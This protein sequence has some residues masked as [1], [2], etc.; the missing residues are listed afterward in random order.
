[1]RGDSFRRQSEMAIEYASRNGLKLD[2][3]L[4]FQD[5]GVS[6]FHGKNAETGHLREFLMAVESGAVAKGSYL[7]VESLD[8]ISRQT[9]RKA[10]NLLGEIADAGITI[11]TLADGRAYTTENLD[12]DPMA[13]MMALLIF[14]RANEE[15]ATKSRR[16]RAAWEAKRA[17]AASKPLTA[18]CPAWLRL[19]SDRSGFEI[20]EERAEVVRG[21][22]DMALAGKGQHAI[23]DALNKRGVAT[24][25]DN[26]RAPAAHW[27]RSYV[28]KVLSSSSVVGSYTPRV[29]ERHDGKRV[30]KALD[31]V[32]NYYPAIVSAEVFQR[33]AI[34][35]QSANDPRRGRNAKTPTRHLLAGLAK[36]PLCGGTMTRVSKGSSKRAGRPNLVCQRA[37]AGAGCQYHSVPVEWVD[38]ALKVF[39]DVIVGSSPASGNSEALNAEYAEVVDRIEKLDATIDQL[40]DTI[41]QRPSAAISKRLARLEAERDTQI[42]K[43]REM[44]EA[45]DNSHH[46]FVRRRLGGLQDGLMAAL[47]TNEAEAIAAANTRLR[48]N[49][50][51]VT[52]D[53][54]RGVLRFDWKHGASTEIPYARMAEGKPQSI[55]APLGSTNGEAD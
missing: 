53:Y 33:V 51:G 50:D 26:G 44:R 43:R 4:T 12:N 34:L 41:V 52:V 5:L 21:I 55:L 13:L 45:I 24:W 25:G 37:K 47:E 3:T 40:V 19:K 7:L 22:Y 39:G 20:I 49:M 23:A 14:I 8:R 1:M 17:N 31:P 32:P 35:R 6:A 9:A 11:V 38:N 28:V 15:S 29:T 16:I 27:H 36:C 18:R 42:A 2:D 54:Q 30:F 46:E 10:I 48:E